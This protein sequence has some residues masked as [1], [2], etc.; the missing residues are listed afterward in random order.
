LAAALDPI[1]PRERVALMDALRGFAIFGILLVNMQFFFS[2]IYL[3]GRS[4]EWW[5]SLADRA[6]EWAIQF[7]AQGKFYSMFSFL[8]GVGAAVQLQRAQARGDS[9]ARFFA[10]R[11]LWLL[12]IGLTHAFLIWFGDILFFYAVIGF[13]LIAFARRKYK[14]LTIWTVILLLLPLL[15]MGGIV[16]ILELARLL[17]ESAAEV[18]RLL[19]ET[20]QQNLDRLE[21]AR[22]VYPSS[23]FGRILELRLL[24]WR[25]VAGATLIW[26]PNILALFLIGLQVGR[27]DLLRNVPQHLPGIRRW[28]GW[29]LPLGIV[30]NLA[31]L[32]LSGVADPSVPSPAMWLQQLCFSVGAPALSF[33][34]VLLITLLSQSA[35]WPRRLAP[36]Q[37]VGRMALTN[38]LMHSVV[39]TML[40][41]GYGLGLYGRVAPSVGLVLTVTMFLLQIPLSVWWLSRFRFGPVEWLWRSLSYRG[42]QPMRRDPGSGLS[43]SGL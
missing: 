39:F 18:D 14:T 13:A 33:S 1:A 3:V 28:L 20:V 42:F 37:A 4:A 15:I 23:G 2:P 9:F 10:R 34:Y 17:P 31:G 24:Q 12:L 29:L 22:E 32:A 40:A 27:R 5:P 43:G 25:T 7:L 30:A 6:V 35:G 21:R 26:G 19:A 16:G 41:N 36:L 8:F 11:M 38:Y